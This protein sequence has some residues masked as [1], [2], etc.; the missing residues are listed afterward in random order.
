MQNGDNIVGGNKGDTGSR[1]TIGSS[2]FLRFT[3]KTSSECF[4]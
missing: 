3:Q 2:P 1:F 4:I